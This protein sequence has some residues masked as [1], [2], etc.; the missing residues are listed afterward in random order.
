MSEEISLNYQRSR[1]RT[2]GKTLGDYF[3]KEQ[4]VILGD[5]TVVSRKVHL[6]PRDT[7]GIV[8]IYPAR[9]A[10]IAYMKMVEKN[11]VVHL[12]VLHDP[13]EIAITDLSNRLRYGL[14]KYLELTPDKDHGSQAEQETQLLNLTQRIYLKTA[15]GEGTVLKPL[16]SLQPPG[17]T[18]TSHIHILAKIPEKYYGSIYCIADQAEKAVTYQGY[19]L[20]KIQGIIHINKEPP[21]DKNFLLGVPVNRH[22]AASPPEVKRQ[23]FT[24]VILSLAH[25][26]GGLEIAASLLDMI[27]PAKSVSI[28]RF[29]KRFP[30]TDRVLHNLALL[31]F[32]RKETFG[33]TLTGTGKELKDFLKTHRKG[34][35]TQIRKAIRNIPP[36]TGATPSGQF[37]RIKA[38]STLS[39]DTRK[40]AARDSGSRSNPIAVPETVIKAARRKAG[41]K[42]RQ[43]VIK[44]KD[45]EV[46]IVSFQERDARVVLPFTRSHTELHKKLLTLEPEGLTPVAKGLETALTLIRQSR[47]HNPMLVLITDGRPNT[48]AAVNTYHNWYGRVGGFR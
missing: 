29:R 32:I 47:P 28:A 7:N 19:R 6:E 33:Y 5:F 36:V 23:N 34:L 42:N 3:A 22:N 9:D 43:F 13:A 46:A 18:L 31:N 44:E 2:I 40:T 14:A 25:E 37:C 24:Q 8:H 20:R 39:F 26:F 11:Q 38:S 45:L 15:G 4:G 27:T 41:E 30:N 12:D 48:P 17:G 1:L 10:G 16:R 21:I 35:E